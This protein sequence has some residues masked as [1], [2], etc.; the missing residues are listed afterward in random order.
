MR[1]RKTDKKAWLRILEAFLAILIVLSAVLVI[2]VKQKPQTD[3][4]QEVYDVQRQVLDIISKN[5]SL[6]NDILVQSNTRVN[7]LI[8]DLIPRNW[9]YSTNICDVNLICPNLEQIH[10]TEVYATEIIISSN[11]TQY[12]PKKLRFFVWI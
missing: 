2:M 9:N 1:Q 10:E 4:S 12:S 8:Y 11:L 6:R 3:Y 7:A 5:N